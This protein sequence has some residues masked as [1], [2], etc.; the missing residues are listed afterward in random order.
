MEEAIIMASMDHPNLLPL[1][2][3]CMTSQIM[4]VSELM[5]CGCL[6]DYV[7][8]NRNKI[9]S[10][11]MMNWSLQIARGMEYLEQNRLVHRDL[12][13]RNVLLK[14]PHHAKITDFG[15]AKILD[16]NQDEYKSSGGKMPIK[17]LAIECLFQKTFTH[18]SDVW[19]FGVTVWELLSYGAK[20]YEGVEPRDVPA[21]LER[22]ERL[23]QPSICTIHLFSLIIKCWAQ[24]PDARPTFATLVAELAGMAAD[25]GRYL[26]IEG[27]Q[28]MRLPSY[29]RQDERLLYLGQLNID[30]NEAIV[31]AA[32]YFNPDG[33]DG[34][35]NA[36]H[37]PVDTPLPPST[38]VQKF[39]PGGIL[40]PPAYDQTMKSSVYKRSQHA[41][42]TLVTRGMQYRAADPLRM[43][44]ILLY[45]CGV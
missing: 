25:P 33:G 32:E 14:N 35:Q 23:Q 9:G 6:K 18:K 22:G 37:T 11:H 7:Q 39:F 34:S 19:A 10:R 38:P 44:E 3:V 8:N 24:N 13:A 17:W 42:D 43:G 31:S 41:N 26:V 40:P 27:D 45:M 30:E 5:V 21:L 2:A 29:P 12:A 36:L 28:L 16:I 20:P 1:L 15:L 4:L